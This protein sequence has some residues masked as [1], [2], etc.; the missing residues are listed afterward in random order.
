MTDATKKQE[1]I[2][3]YLVKIVERAHSSG[4]EHWY[5]RTFLSLEGASKYMQQYL[6]DIAS[7]F[8]YPEDWEVD[9]MGC[10]FPEPDI[11]SVEKLQEHLVK[12]KKNLGYDSP[13]WGPQ[14]D[15][16]CQAPREVFLKTTQVWP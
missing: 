4:A 12:E 14:S 1:P 5:E 9:D 6:K 7:D 3:A 13:I 2:N 11:F 8:N 10:E 16:E 15:W